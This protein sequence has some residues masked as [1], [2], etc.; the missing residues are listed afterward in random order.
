MQLIYVS[1]EENKFGIKTHA[2]WNDSSNHELAYCPLFSLILIHE[3]F[4]RANNISLQ[5]FLNFDE[6]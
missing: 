2:H 1:K 3:Q 5:L 4:S 6:K